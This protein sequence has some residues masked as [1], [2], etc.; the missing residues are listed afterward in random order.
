MVGFYGLGLSNEVHSIEGR[1][2]FPFLEG[3]YSGACVLAILNLMIIYYMS[4]SWNDPVRL[5]YL[6]AYFTFNL[7]LLFM[8]NSRISILI[9]LFVA[10]LLSFKVIEKT[11]GLFVGSLFTVPILLNSGLI[12][13]QILTLPFFVSILKRVDIEDVTTF[14]GRAFIWRNAMNWLTDDQRGIFLGNGY[15]GHYFLDLISDVAKLWNSDIKD[16]HHMHLHSSS[17]EILVSQGIV[18]FVIFMLLF[19]K[20]F[21]YYKRKY[22]NGDE[23]GIFFAVG[24]F[25]LFIMQVDTFV[26]LESSGSVIFSLLLANVVIAH[27]PSPDTPPSSGQFA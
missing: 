25:L 7:A 16:Y 21:T 13:Y 5:S 4:K 23:Q 11:K 3:F 15:K 9:F 24:V 22:R 12:L 17:F 18:G 1:V 6:A 27:P 26:Y 10:L 14:N 2:N 20:L 8:I 19:Y